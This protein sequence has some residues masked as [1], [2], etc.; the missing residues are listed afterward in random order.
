MPRRGR[1]FK[2]KDRPYVQSTSG[3]TPINQN[4]NGEQKIHY[5][6][7]TRDGCCRRNRKHQDRVKRKRNTMIEEKSI[8]RSA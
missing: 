5:V 1:V 6:R 4:D 8:M 2:E 3:L 7:R